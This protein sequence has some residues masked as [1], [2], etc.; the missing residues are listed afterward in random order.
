METLRLIL[1]LA[2]SFLLFLDFRRSIKVVSLC[3][4]NDLKYGHTLFRAIASFAASA[5]FILLFNADMSSRQGFQR[6]PPL[7]GRVLGH[8]SAPLSG[9]PD[10][11]EGTSGYEAVVRRVIDGDTVVLGN[12]ERVVYIGADAPEAARRSG[13]AEP[14]AREAYIL[15]RDLVEGKVVKL[16]FDNFKRDKYNRLRA[17][18]YQGERLINNEMVLNG[19]AKVVQYYPLTKHR[20]L[21]YSSEQEAIERNRGIWK[22]REL[23]RQ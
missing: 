18:V 14:M 10:G 20:H 17:Y 6:L 16:E 5:L 3:R 19:L 7:L 2:A 13:R 23:K 4:A 22:L 11:E 8:A 12:G 21:L 15:N 9:N 1:E